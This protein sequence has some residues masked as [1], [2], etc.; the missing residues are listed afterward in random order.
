M[1]SHGEIQDTLYDFVM[2]D[3]NQE[4]MDAVRLHLRTCTECRAAVGELEQLA[5][6]FPRPLRRPSDLVDE[7]HWAELA[8]RIER[9]LPSPLPARHAHALT[10]R[11][12]LRM[13]L[14]APRPAIALALAALVIAVTATLVL[15]PWERGEQK[16][17]PIAETAAVRGEAATPAMLESP[18][19]ADIAAHL[20]RSKNLLVELTNKQVEPEATADLSVER[21]AS[22]RLL[23][24]NRRYRSEVL[25][26]QSA[27]VLADLEKIMIEVANSRER[28]PASDLD[29]IRQG[30]RQQN[31][32][33]KVRMAEQL[34]S[35]GMIV[36]VSGH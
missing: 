35:R 33:F 32:L 21:D 28:A 4:E 14:P 22:K 26:P 31:L 8:A 27:D 12:R 29:L 16:A 24:D 10:L 36:R 6:A 18:P 11:E 5:A 13:L 19:G 23:L 2:N 3:L 20:R 15:R 17:E 1:K 7:A 30:I 25:D 9:N 34:S